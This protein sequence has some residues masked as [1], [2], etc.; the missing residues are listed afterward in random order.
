MHT[1]NACRLLSII[2]Q[3]TDLCMCVVLYFIL[4]IFDNSDF[5]LCESYPDYLV[6]AAGLTE[7]EIR[8]AA[9]FRSQRRLPCVTYRH[10]HRYTVT[11]IFRFIFEEGLLTISCCQCA[12]VP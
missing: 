4:Q 2:M 8:E 11:C 7:S 1:F 10:P 3:F 6:V 9:Q 12:V 5:S